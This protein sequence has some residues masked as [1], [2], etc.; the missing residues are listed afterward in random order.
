MNWRRHAL[1]VSAG[2]GILGLAVVAPTTL[3]HLVTLAR[4]PAP[5]PS[6]DVPSLSGL[7]NGALGDL[8]SYLHPAP[9]NQRAPKISGVD[10]ITNATGSLPPA[11]TALAYAPEAAPGT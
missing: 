7:T 1:L 11:A 8:A 3:G 4:L 9:L 2:C 5:A 10:A 6:T